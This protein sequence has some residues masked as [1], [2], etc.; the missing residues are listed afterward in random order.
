MQFP[1]KTLKDVPLQGKA[2]LV[3]TGFDVPLRENDG[4]MVIT[5]DYRIV[6]GLPTI[7]YLLE[8][9]CKIVLVSK[10]G[11]PD[12]VDKAL[13]LEP[14]AKH[15]GELLEMDVKFCSETTGPVARHAKKS[16]KAGEVLLLENLFFD[17]REKAN[18]L[19]FAKE[20]AE[21]CDY[22]VQDCFSSA[23]REQALM[24]VVN[25]ALPG[26]AGL[27]LIEEYEKL[28]HAV[29]E[30]E[31]PRCA[32][33]G[34]AKIETK[35]DLLNKLID[36]MD[37]VI[38]GGALANTFLVA[39]GVNVGSSKY[40][41][42]QVQTAKDILQKLEDKNGVVY[43]LPDIDVAVSADPKTKQPRKE[44]SVGKVA[45]EEW[46]LDLGEESIKKMME[47]V[48]ES[49]TVIWNGPIGM[50]SKPAFADG[51]R[52]LAEYLAKNNKK[53]DS[54]IGGG[55]TA[56]FINTLGLVGKMTHVS[57]GGGASLQLISGQELP[58]VESLL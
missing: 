44:V 16:L 20:V 35:I 56:D 18:D 48:S 12:G 15:L 13:S 14:V 24:S 47:L 52:V 29:E 34:G 2:V 53:V 46:I 40:D 39:K 9:D 10:L 32:V 5:D 41:K 23:H 6:K 30:S 28:T 36:T 22:F 45:P 25:Q 43:Y 8:Q 38:I 57:T 3:R 33:V 50:T 17:P 26:S 42:D 4:E 21:M 7:K 51:S 55:D 58:A 54:I 27:L 19:E 37:S 31:Q 11:R 49:K 1:K